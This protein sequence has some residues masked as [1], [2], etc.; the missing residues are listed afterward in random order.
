MLDTKKLSQKDSL[1]CL[2]VLKAM[3]SCIK[4]SQPIQLKKLLC[5]KTKADLF[6]LSAGY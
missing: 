2:L 4:S 1:N 6:N 5:K 3:Y